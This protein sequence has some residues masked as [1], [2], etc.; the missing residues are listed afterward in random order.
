MQDYELERWLRL[1]CFANHYHF[2]SLWHLRES[3]LKQRYFG[4]DQYSTRS[5]HPGVSINRRN[6]CSLQDTV[7]MLIGSSRKLGRAC[8]VTGVFKNNP[9]EKKTYFQVL[10]PVSVLPEHF[11]SHDGMEAEVERND[12]KSHL[13]KTEYAELEKMFGKGDGDGQ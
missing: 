8:V 13:N 2:G 11:F 7:Q 6:V 5:G 12:F 4:Y 1:L 3:L 10:R 9:N